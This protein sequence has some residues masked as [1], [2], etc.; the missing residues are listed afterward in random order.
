MT[1]A[2]SLAASVIALGFASSLTA[3]LPA[4]AAPAPCDGAQNY[5]AQSGAQTLRIDRLA[6]HR[7]P[8]R[9]RPS[10]KSSSSAAHDD[11]SRKQKESVTD[12]A[13]ELLGPKADLTSGDLGDSGQG[14]TGFLSGTGDLV[15]SITNGSVT[16]AG[17][18]LNSGSGGQGGGGP[19]SDDDSAT[20]GGTPA[21]DDDSATGAGTPAS[22]DDSAIGGVGLGE[23]KT[24]MIADA[25][26]NAVAIGR[27]ADAKGALG[28]PLIQAAPPNA[29]DASRHIASGSAGPLELGAGDLG[30]HAAW[31]PAMACGKAFGDAARS[32]ATVKHIDLLD[33]DLVH[34]PDAIT[35]KSW[36]SLTPSDGGPRSVATATMTADRL[37]LAGGKIKLQV[38]HPPTLTASMGTG[39]GGSV[40]YK[41]AQVKVTWPGGR[42][43]TLNTP[44]DSVDVS[45]GAQRSSES[46]SLPRL[47]GLLPASRLPLPNVPGLPSIATPATESAPTAGNGVTVRISLGEARQAT[48]GHAIAAKAS[49]IQVAIAEGYTDDSS[50]GRGRGGYGDVS[51]S[52]VATM[53]LGL[54][55]AAAV[56][57]EST[58]NNAGGGAAATALPITGSRALL[59]A[60]GGLAFIVAGGAALVL[61]RRRR[62]TLS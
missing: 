41:P 11:S 58:P 47:D 56:A 39:A 38:L 12:S 53:S 24:A 36:T 59:L 22:D 9:E 42:S 57:P 31:D 50:K 52:V 54:L 1:P 55:E 32:T 10:I 49:A 33:G 25:R 48:K 13:R 6:W 2:R 4:F 26:T 28:R 20:G 15:K 18:P 14:V 60:A 8:D 44:G 45:L 29:A 17:G 37:N 30:T 5:A 19:A 46:A 35:S 23:T 51:S 21:S 16:A 7:S 61:G 43:K 34:A 62:R 27:M 40:V 3:P